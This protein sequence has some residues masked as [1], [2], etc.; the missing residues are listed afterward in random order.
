MAKTPLKPWHEVLRLRAD[1]RSEELSQKQFAADLYDVMMGK[2]ASGSVYHD[3]KEFFALTYPTTK[4]R[5]LARDV[6]WRLAGKS[7]KAVRQ[8]HMTFGGGKTHSLITLVHLCRDPGTLPDIPAV[9]QFK[10]HCEIP[11]PQA[12]IAAVVFDRL[13]AEMG[14]EVRDP[15]G[16]PARLKMP[17]SVL[18]WQLAGAEGMKV[19]KESGEERSHVP[20]TNVLEELLERARQTVPAVLILF[21]E[22][23]WYVRTMADQ[24][25]AWVGRMSDFLHSLT[26]AVA[27]VPQ[28]CL[29]ASLL[30]SDTKKLDELGRKISK[31]LYDEFKRVADDGIQPVEQ[32]DVP[33]ILRRRLF[34]LESYTD[35][36]LWPQQV[37]AALNGIKAIDEQ[38]AK[39]SAIE[40]KRFEDAY[41]FHPDLIQVL[42]GKWTMLE[43]FQQTRGI[44]K[45]LASALRD[46]EKWQDPAPIV[47]P[48]VF[49]T[50]PA[51]EGLGVATR[52]LTTIAQIE[53]YDGRKQNWTAILEA[54]LAHARRAQDDL[55]GLHY[56]EIEQA[57]IATFLHS[58]PIGR[59]A[60]TR[61][62]LL[63]LGSGA[64]DKIELSKGLAR[65]AD[66]SW[67]LDD[68]FT[69]EREAG[70]PKVWR[71]G[72]KPNLKQM[73]YDARQHI[74]G[75]VLEEV[76]ENQIAK[77][78]KLWEG[79]TGFGVKLHKLPGKPSEVEDDGEFHFAILKPKAASEPGR[80]PNPEAKRFLDENTGPDNP[81]ARNRNA[82]VLAVPAP[83]AIDIAREKVRDYLGWEKV[84]DM[85][86]ERNDIDMARTAMLETNLR[87]AG[88]EMASQIVMAYSV[89]VTVNDKNETMAYRVNVDNT[90]LFSRIVADRKIRIES[91]AV[92]AEAL[93]PGGPYDLWAEGEQARFVKDLVG[94]FASTARLPK[95]LNRAAILETLI[96]G[97]EAGD[98]VL[99]VTRSDKSVRS[100]WKSRPDS[101]T[102]EEPS[103]EV[104][105]SDAA[106]LTELDWTL[107][108]PGALPGLWTGDALA[109][110][111]LAEYFSGTH[112]EPVDKGGYTENLLIPAATAEAIAAAVTAAVKNGRLWLVNGTIS[113]L[114]EEVPAGF[115]NEGASLYSPPTTLSSTGI[116]PD[117]LPSA[118][119]EATTTAHLIHAALSALKGQGRP[120]PWLTVKRALEEAFQLGLIERT[121]DSGP[122]PCDLGGAGLVKVRVPEGG[123][124][125]IKL[126]PVIAYGAKRA[127]SNLKIDEVQDFADRIDDLKKLAAG[128]KFHIQVSVEIGE[129]G[130]L[131]EQLVEDIND[132]LSGIKPGW[133]LE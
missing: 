133:K 2:N 18:A 127:V 109:F 71:L 97:C 99:R 90:P 36:K 21:D 77:A 74:D 103:L 42:Y 84:R 64:P 22:V 6:M 24:D 125:G 70:L 44:L 78:G 54:E 52:E 8:L 86:K 101:H 33:E 111:R 110:P 122:W 89:V 30:A 104:V 66:R 91:T 121:L 62:L 16:N 79:A 37:Y 56:R 10:A 93:L 49:L 117:S 129:A 25:P 1:I 82:V 81:R 85:L 123:E 29:V 57:V 13:D 96:A 51:D 11:L 106:Q 46:A 80:H 131:S 31:E 58:Q 48:Q 112:F 14:M 38:T 67:Y 100:F 3:P 43:G 59:R 55:G 108:L 53:Q 102:L 28:C 19:L 87:M 124:P 17:W 20:A 50:D 116:L 7:E 114:G 27:K 40:E 5:D 83:G 68:T 4:L 63:L 65:W 132:L 60:A 47:G 92:N 128:Q 32:H 9:A 45:T 119:S 98:F 126:K 107:L 69:G 76:L 118:W 61:E 41:P 120:L 113:V 72:S 39:N 15:Q 34:D 105:L 115:L 94:A 35:R 88:G 26:Q 23:L 95:M 12:R 130:S 75:T 73:H